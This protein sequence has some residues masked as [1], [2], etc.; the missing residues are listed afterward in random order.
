M[1]LNISAESFQ[2]YNLSFSYTTKIKIQV[3]VKS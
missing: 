2:I 1:A 3:E